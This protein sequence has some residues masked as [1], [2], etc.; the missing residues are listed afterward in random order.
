MAGK[1]KSSLSGDD[2]LQRQL[3]VAGPLAGKALA[4]A[5]FEEMEKVMTGAK[6]RTPVDTGVLRASGTVLK[7]KFRGKKVEIVAGFGGAAKTYA[8]PVHE[9]LTVRHTVG[10]AKFLERAF[11]DR[12]PRMD[13]NLADGVRRALGRLGG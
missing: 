13:I 7:P 1:F 2:E 12:L 6:M 5:A 10:E 8:V 11:L 4:S 3:K 9:N